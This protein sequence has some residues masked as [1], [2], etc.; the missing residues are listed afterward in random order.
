MLREWSF[1][2]QSE[3]ERKL[4]TVECSVR[5]YT[6]NSFSERERRQGAQRVKFLFAAREKES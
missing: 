1:A 4:Y 5:K 3:M 2:S 6:E